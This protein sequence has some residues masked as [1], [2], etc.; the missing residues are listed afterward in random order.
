MDLEPE[1]GQ[2]TL[3]EP[4]LRDELTSNLADALKDSP[5]AEGT[6]EIPPVETAEQK[7]DRVRDAEGKFAKAPPAPVAAAPAV[8][9]PKRPSSWK[10]EHWADYDKIVDTV[11]SLRN[12]DLSEFGRRI[13]NVYC[14]EWTFRRG[15]EEALCRS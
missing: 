6:V 13:H 9:A 15:V 11:C 4:S 7:A 14:K 3:P 2:E 12:V 5:P 10:K 1:V 8:E